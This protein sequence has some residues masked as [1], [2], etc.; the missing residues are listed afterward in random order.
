MLKTIW[1]NT[2]FFYDKKTQQTTNIKK[3]PKLIK[4]IYEKPIAIILLMVE[5][6]MH[7]L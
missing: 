2:A 1:Q 4:G 7:S 3:L 5:D 6:L